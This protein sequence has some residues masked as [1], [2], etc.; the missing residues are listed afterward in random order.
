MQEF[1]CSRCGER[2]YGAAQAPGRM[3]CGACD[4]RL[5]PARED[6]APTSG[7]AGESPDRRVALSQLEEA[8][9]ELGRAWEGFYEPDGGVPELAAYRRMLA[10]EALVLACGARV[11]GI[12]EDL[13]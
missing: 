11:S 12:G 8:R 10:A 9:L 7:P 5:E 13:G 2:F 6:L 4:A 1:I 3:S